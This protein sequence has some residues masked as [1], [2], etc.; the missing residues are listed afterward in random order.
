MAFDLYSF[1][2]IQ[3]K[4]CRKTPK[5]SICFTNKL[6]EVPGFLNSKLLFFKKYIFS[7]KKKTLLFIL[8]D[9]S[10]QKSI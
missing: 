6:S 2:L 5:E 1:I 4:K 9:Y 8:Y 10:N 3:L 7:N